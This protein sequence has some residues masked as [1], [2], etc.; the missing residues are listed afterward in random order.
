MKNILV[1]VALSF[2]VGN[3]AQTNADEILNNYFEN[4]GGIENWQ[5]LQGLKMIGKVNGQ[6]MEIPIE[7]IQLKDGRQYVKIN[8]QG[9]ELMQGVYDG[10]VLWNTNFMTQKAEVMTTEDTENF[11]KNQVNDFPTPFLDYKEKGYKIELLEDET[12]EGTECFKLKLTQNPVLVDGKEEDNVSFYYFE[13]EN[14][15]PIA[16]EMEIKSGPM[17]G[18]MMKST[19]SDYEEVEGLYFPFSL[20]QMGGPLSIETIELNPDVNL[21]IFEMPKEEEEST[22]PPIKEKK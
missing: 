18:Q 1:L 9:K 17:K 14:F 13:K 3:Y 10:K 7:I 15:V 11:K 19:M 2:F 4:T 21:D 16:M 6:G 5:K 22:A 20:S 12:M 8:F